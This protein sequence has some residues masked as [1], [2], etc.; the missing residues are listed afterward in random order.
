MQILSIY[1]AE[2]YY[3][4][5]SAGGWKD[6]SLLQKKGD[7]GRP[8]IPIC[9][10]G[11]HFSQALYDF[12]ASINI[13]P[14]VLYE[15]IHG[16]L[17]LYTTMCLQLAD[18]TLCYPKGIV[19]DICIQVGNSYV[20]VDFV[21]IEIGGDEKAPIILGRP[22]LSTAKAIIY[23]NNANICFNIKGR[24]EKFTFKNYILKSSAHP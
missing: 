15:K 17:L 18:Q 3:G 19:E 10:G 20:P 22:F 2:S 16:D 23:A 12:G 1:N 9:I 4:A 24:K 21:V 7:L 5:A 11:N 8:D 13:I 14:M 6:D